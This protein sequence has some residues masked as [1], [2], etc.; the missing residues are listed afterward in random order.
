VARDIGELGD[1]R[2]LAGWMG[3]LCEAI[4]TECWNCYKHLVRGE[5]RQC[6]KEENVRTRW[7]S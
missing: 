3:N 1:E 5:L 7:G 2:G 4:G 6:E